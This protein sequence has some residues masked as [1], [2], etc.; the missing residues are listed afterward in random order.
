[1]FGLLEEVLAT[2][3]AL[4]QGTE[5]LRLPGNPEQLSDLS[6]TTR[7]AWLTV[8]LDMTSPVEA[9]QAVA[10]AIYR[11]GWIDIV[12][13]NAGTCTKS[14]DFDVLTVPGVDHAFLGLSQTP[15]K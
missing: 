13:N 11:F 3:A 5:C 12:V 9:Q 14:T 15:V 4:L 1:M 10:A 6:A 7:I 8:K 2:W